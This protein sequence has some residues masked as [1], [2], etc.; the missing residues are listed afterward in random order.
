MKLSDVLFTQNITDAT[1]YAVRAEKS[2]NRTEKNSL[3]QQAIEAL[4][5][6]IQQIEASM[7]S[8][9]PR[10]KNNYT[11][12]KLI[13][14][15]RRLGYAFTRWENDLNI[16]RVQEF[17]QHCQSYKELLISSA[18]DERHK[19]VSFGILDYIE[20][21]A[22]KFIP[23]TLKKTG[24]PQK[25]TAT[26]HKSEA[27]G[28]EEKRPKKHV[29]FTLPGDGADQ[30]NRSGSAV[31]SEVSTQLA[32]T[33]TPSQSRKR[34]RPVTPAPIPTPTSSTA[35]KRRKVQQQSS[36]ISRAAARVSETSSRCITT[37]P[38]FFRQPLPPVIRLYEHGIY[39]LKESNKTDRL[40][41]SKL[42]AS[43]AMALY[44]S[45]KCHSISKSAIS[46]VLAAALVM[47][48]K[49]NNQKAGNKAATY[50]LDIQK[51]YQL[52][53]E[54]CPIDSNQ[55]NEVIMR[56]LIEHLGEELSKLSSDQVHRILYTWGDIW[57]DIVDKD[58]YLWRY[59][60]WKEVLELASNTS[61]HL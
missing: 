8:A 5:T 7:I 61:F 52:P 1:G 30:V 26:L 15:T 12:G 58:N 43:F 49:S 17:L 60:K 16:D 48:D 25:P 36:G 24:R 31:S 18:I 3:W 59:T 22:S 47:T 45:H 46:K 44:R 20:T 10:D 28:S 57:E 6:E 19:K 27:I 29:R 55:D 38:K 11:T 39:L 9:S 21:E 4:T 14:E 56:L 34:Q 50:V 2:N 33:A 32:T 54:V 42:L 37:G 51:H 40:Q 23:P 53:F 13:L 35:T 41:V